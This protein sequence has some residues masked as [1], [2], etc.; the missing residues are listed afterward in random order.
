MAGITL[1]QAEAKLALWIAADDAVAK[2]QS[3]RVGD[4]TLTRADAD[5]I[6]KRIDKWDRRVKRLSRGGIRV[7]GVTPCG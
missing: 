5:L 6:D 3:Y 4:R 1:A 7:T 2:S